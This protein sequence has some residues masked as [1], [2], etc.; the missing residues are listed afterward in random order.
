VF[1]QDSCPAR[2]VGLKHKHSRKCRDHWDDQCCECGQR[3]GSVVVVQDAPA[4]Y[5]DDENHV[6]QFSLDE[7]FN[8]MRLAEMVS[9]GYYKP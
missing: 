8:L 6:R 3:A 5:V 2:G 7:R 1:W 9:K 4:Q